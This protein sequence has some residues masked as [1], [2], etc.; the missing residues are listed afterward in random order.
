MEVN[1]FKDTCRLCLEEN[2]NF[3]IYSQFG[4]N[5]TLNYSDLA[6]SL[7][8]LQVNSRILNYLSILFF[9]N[10]ANNSPTDTST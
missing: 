6:T 1:E 4:K 8:N 2:R 9:N 5:K 10:F 3:S 7:L